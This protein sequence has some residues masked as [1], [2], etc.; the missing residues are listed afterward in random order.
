MTTIRIPSALRRGLLLAACTAAA[1]PGFALAQG[2]FPDKPVRVIVSFPPGGAA[3]Q[4]ARA[5]SDPLSKALGQP[6]I[7]EN[8]AGANGNIAGDYVA[9]QPADGYTVLINGPAT[10]VIMP[11]IQPSLAGAVGRG[12]LLG[13]ELRHRGDIDNAAA[14]TLR[15][16]LLRRSL[17]ADKRAV[18]VDVDDLAPVLV[19]L[20]QE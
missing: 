6:V 4:I 5:V 13:G 11:A 17:G 19:G 20:V 10:H 18:Q 1:L 12:V 14:R 9:K 15:Q 8:R 3:D 7:V 16:H 2:H